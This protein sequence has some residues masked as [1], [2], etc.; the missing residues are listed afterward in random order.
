[1]DSQADSAS[2]NL[3]L[4]CPVCCGTGRDPEAHAAIV[5][6]DGTCPMCCCPL[7]PRYAAWHGRV[8]VSV[9]VGV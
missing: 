7:H 4:L 5:D 3:T 1:M 6:D 8:R 2:V 9:E